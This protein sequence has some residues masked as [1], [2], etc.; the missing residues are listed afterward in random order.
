[1]TAADEVL[2]QYRR[3]LTVERGL[4]VGTARG[5]VDIVRPF[6]E[7]RVI[8][9]SAVELWELSPADVLGF[10]LA[11]TGRRSR[12]SAKLLVSALRSLLRFLHVQG[13]IAEPLAAA[14]PAVAQAARGP[15]ARVAGRAGRGGC[16]ESCDRSTPVGRRDYAILMLLSRLGL[17][18][19][20]VAALAARRLD[21]RAG[22]IVV[23]GKGSRIERLPLPTAVSYCTSV[24]PVFGFCVDVA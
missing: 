6:V 3:Y 2:E 16:L 24:D 18:G 21:W 23:R 19:G 14:V 4:T 12:K 9:T 11:E 7:S 10:L 22:E 13:L 1:M 8:G 20:E 5:Y 17:R 15:P